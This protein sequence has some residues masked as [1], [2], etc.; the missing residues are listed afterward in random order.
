[1]GHP[2]LFLSIIA[3]LMLS[4]CSTTVPN[5]A[6]G[7]VKRGEET[8]GQHTNAV[9]ALN[10][11]GS[12]EADM[13]LEGEVSKGCVEAWRKALA[14]DKKG[15]L[16]QLD[17]MGRQYPNISTITFMKGQVLDHCGDK[18]E[19]IE[20][21]R[22]AVTNKEFSTIHI[23]KLAEA[24]RATNQNQEAAV[25]YRRLLVSAPDFPPGKIGLAK[26]LLATDKKSSEA[27]K[28]LESVVDSGEDLDKKEAE[29]LLA[30]MNAGSSK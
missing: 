1:M 29:K 22:N 12:F 18:K 28:E 11:Q 25:E 20:F 23:F 24:L 3:L 21:Y 19:A 10:K 30:Q 8:F 2:R 9:V 6:M 17:Q 27:R 5:S 7:D 14:G 26:A 15:A 4:G 13:T 16:A